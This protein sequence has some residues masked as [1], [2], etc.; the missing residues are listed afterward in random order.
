[1]NPNSTVHKGFLVS[2]FPDYLTIERDGKTLTYQPGHVDKIKSLLS[3]GRGFQEFET[4]PDRIADPPYSITFNENGV[5]VLN[6]NAGH[7]I[8]FT[9]GECD[10]LVEAFAIS[11]DKMR[12]DRTLSNRSRKGFSFANTPEPVIE[13]KY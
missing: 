1:M 8:P 11:I 9:F 13:G 12:D 4:L 2:V 3:I 6:D 5:H 7:G 10:A